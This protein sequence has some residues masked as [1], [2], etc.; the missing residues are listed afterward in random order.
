M[1]ASFNL[2]A[3]KQKSAFLTPTWC[4][5]K[6]SSDGLGKQSDSNKKF[7]MREHRCFVV[8]PISSHAVLTIGQPVRECKI[9]SLVHVDLR[10]LPVSILSRRST[11]EIYPVI[12]AA[13]VSLRE[14]NHKL[15][16]PLITS[17][18]FDTSVAE[19]TRIH[20]R[21]K[22]EKKS[23]LLL[24]KIRCF[25]FDSSFELLS[26]TAGDAIPGFSLAPIH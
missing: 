6:G 24:K 17:Y 20:H 8:F 7:V 11:I 14:C 23:R 18:D 9:Y 13:V 21:D 10:A 16:R 19:S 1:M 2:E 3:D 22:L 12:E 5:P 25:R 15:I 4:S 26:I